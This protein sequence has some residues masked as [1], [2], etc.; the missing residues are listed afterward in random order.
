MILSAVSEQCECSVAQTY[1]TNGVFDCLKGDSTQVV[2]YRA[3]MSAGTESECTMLV[4]YLEDWISSGKASIV[5]KGNRLTVDPGCMVEIESLTSDVEC[6]T[7]EESQDTE[8]GDTT[9]VIAGAAAGVIVL[10]I[11]I[12]LAIGMFMRWKRRGGR[13]VS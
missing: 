3:M 7:T 8:G 10:L 6:T 11:V 13:L 1:I 4:S 12:A 5:V 2:L 9:A